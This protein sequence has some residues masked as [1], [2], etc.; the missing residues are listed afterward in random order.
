MILGW[1]RK[2]EESDVSLCLKES[3]YSLLYK[4]RKVHSSS[5]ILT[6]KETEHKNVRKMGAEIIA[7][8]I[9]DCSRLGQDSLCAYV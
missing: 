7:D 6:Q 1:D 4:E 5:T 3:R 9:L 2:T 8:N